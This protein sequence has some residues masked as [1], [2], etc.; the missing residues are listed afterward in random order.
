MQHPQ[1]M[2]FAKPYDVDHPTGEAFSLGVVSNGE[3]GTHPG[4]IVSY[5]CISVNGKITVQDQWPIDD[6]SKVL[7]VNI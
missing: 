3:Y 5:P 1:L 2:R 7:R 4:L 6:Q